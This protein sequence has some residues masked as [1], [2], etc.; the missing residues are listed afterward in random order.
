MLVI[1]PS[2]DLGAHQCL[3]LGRCPRYVASECWKVGVY[4][5][6]NDSRYRIGM[7]RAGK[8]P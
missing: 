5:E 3:S 4:I 8:C 2:E 1:G 7:P 6:S